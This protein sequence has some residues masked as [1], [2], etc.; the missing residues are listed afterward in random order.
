MKKVFLISAVICFIISMIISGRLYPNASND[1]TTSDTTTF[2]NKVNMV[3]ENNTNGENETLST[4]EIQHEEKVFDAIAEH[5]ESL[6]DE[7]KEPE[8]T[9][10]NETTF[11]RG[12]NNI[13]TNFDINAQNV[14]FAGRFRL[15][16]YCPCSKCCDKYG[17]NRPVDENGEMIVETASGAKAYENHTIAVDPRLIPYGTTV[18][19]EYDGIF[20]EYVAEDCGGAIKNKRIDIYHNSHIAANEFGIKYGKVYLIK[21]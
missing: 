11:I 10:M 13:I 14:S 15:T 1:N 7:V 18:I 5:N 4:Q 16:A 9:L 3:D 19:I 20:Y 21:D 8:I 17:V 12:E 6:V 2:S